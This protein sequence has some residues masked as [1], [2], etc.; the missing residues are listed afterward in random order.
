M[1]KNDLKDRYFKDG[2]VVVRGAV[3]QAELNSVRMEI[4]SVFNGRRSASTDTGGLDERPTEQLRGA[5]LLEYLPQAVSMQFDPAVMDAARQIFGDDFHYVNDISIQRN[6]KL[7]DGRAGWHIDASSNFGLRYLNN[8]LDINRYRFAKIGVYLQSGDC[9]TGGSVDLVPKSHRI[10]RVARG[11]ILRLL[12]SKLNRMFSKLD[13]ALGMARLFGAVSM[14]LQL[15]PGDCIIFD[16]RLIHRSSPPKAFSESKPAAAKTLDK[17]TVYWEVGDKSSAT[18]FL[19]NDL[20]R[21]LAHENVPLGSI[22]AKPFSQYLRLKYPD[23]Y[24]QWYVAQAQEMRVKIAQF[25]N[26]RDLEIAR[27]IYL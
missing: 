22:G 25:E 10:G 13:R 15:Q 19:K 9:P 23:D 21:A 14:D 24:P 8:A 6:Q 18:K 2:Y 7:V 1:L 12:E 3:K 20:V 16:C 11:I 26:D 17:L 5:E 4:I 27:Q